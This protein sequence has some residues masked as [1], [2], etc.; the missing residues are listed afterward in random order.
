MNYPLLAWSQR[1]LRELPLGRDDAIYFIGM[2]FA[3]IVWMCACLASPPG[4]DG[5]THQPTA[6]RLLWPQ[7]AMQMLF[8]CFL[9]FGQLLMNE[10][11]LWTYQAIKIAGPL[12]TFLMNFWRDGRDAGAV[13]GFLAMVNYDIVFFA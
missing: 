7:V 13:Y 12:C 9:M 1:R 5:T 2:I 10:D 11:R 3:R 8:Y 4:G 6:M